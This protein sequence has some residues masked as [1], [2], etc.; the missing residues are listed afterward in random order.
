MLGRRPA[1]S[2]T[3]PGTDR[4][5]ILLQSHE[6]QPR[7]SR[8]ANKVSQPLQAW[9]GKADAIIDSIICIKARQRVGLASAR[10]TRT[11]TQLRSAAAASL[12]E[13][14]NTTPGL[15]SSRICLSRWTSCRTLVTPG[16]LPTC[17]R[18]RTCHCQ[19][20]PCCTGHVVA[21][22]TL[23]D[24]LVISSLA[25]QSGRALAG[26]SE[27]QSGKMYQ[28]QQKVGQLAT[29]HTRAISSM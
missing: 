28:Q 6:S 11:L 22:L 8:H 26:Y 9:P 7:L 24:T 15:S 5:P 29:I 16:V 19:P 4:A 13:E 20:R 10:W 1:C 14:A 17:I 18:T 12:S 3:W 21:T 25:E 2:I 23:Q 27:S